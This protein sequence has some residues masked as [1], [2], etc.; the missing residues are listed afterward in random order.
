MR[1]IIVAVAF[2][3]V[4][5]VTPYQPKGLTGGYEDEREAPGVYLVSA[6]G[7]GHT[8]IATLR[9]YVLRRGQELCEAEGF[10]RM[11]LIGATV[12]TQTDQTP[13]TYV[14]HSN[15]TVTQY[16]GQSY[17]RHAVTARAVCMTEAEF[18][19]WRNGERAKLMGQ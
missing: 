17:S 19:A 3:M 15:S 1:K 14:A 18:Q 12:D 7:N 5:C 13:A 9:S 11:R 10:P 16:G 4:G 8:G 2:A 6:R